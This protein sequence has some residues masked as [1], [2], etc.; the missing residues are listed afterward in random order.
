MQKLR[1]INFGKNIFGL[2][3]LELFCELSDIFYTNSVD[4]NMIQYSY[5]L[6]YLLKF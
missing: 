4:Q 5:S 2:Q 6:V 3:I 1:R